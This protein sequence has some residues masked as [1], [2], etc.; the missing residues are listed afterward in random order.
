MS[1][2]N[3]Q[4]SVKHSSQSTVLH[5]I[6]R[7]IIRNLTLGSQSC[8]IWHQA[9]NTL[10]PSV[11]WGDYDG[12]S[13]SVPTQQL[14]VCFT[15]QEH[16]QKKTMQRWTEKY[17]MSK[18]TLWILVIFTKVTPWIYFI[19]TSD[20]GFSTLVLGILKSCCWILIQLC[21]FCICKC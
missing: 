2:I 9:A 11:D 17:F 19:W 1:D 4:S 8:V 21:Y 18:L 10:I 15:L 3:S 12:P 14:I 13:T 20:G 16:W 6:V 7:T 5:P